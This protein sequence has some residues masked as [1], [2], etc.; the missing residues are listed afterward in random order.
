MQTPNIIKSIC[1]VG[2]GSAGWLT[3]AY[4][5]NNLPWANVTLVESANIPTIG[6]GEATIIN[7][8]DFMKDCGIM[9]GE[10]Q[11]A[12]DAVFK[13]GIL[14]PKWKNETTDIWHPFMFESARM[15]DGVEYTRTVL[16][17][18]AGLDADTW[19]KQAV[20]WYD[21]AVTKKQLPDINKSSV[22][23]HLDAI[24]LA[25]FLSQYCKSKY[26]DRLTHILADVN[27][28]VTDGENI[29]AVETSAGVV[30]NDFYIDCTGFKRILSSS[31]PGSQYINFDHM[32]FTNAAVATPVKY[33]SDDEI[34]PPYTI[35]EA[36][37]HGWI[38]KTS[39]EG[40]I[41]TGLVY[42]DTLLS[43]EAA[44]EYLTAHWGEDRLLTGKFNHIKFKP[45][46]NANNWRG[47]CFSIGLSSGFV[48]PLESTGLGLLV[49]G[50]RIGL[51]ILRKHFYIA[52]DRSFYNS[53]MSSLYVDSFD[54]VALHYMNN[55]RSGAFWD[56]VRTE[57]K[58][59]ATLQARL[60]LNKDEFFTKGS[61]Q[62]SLVFKEDS[63]R[64]WLMA[65]DNPVSQPDNL[66]AANKIKEFIDADNKTGGPT[67]NM[68]VK[69][70]RS[71]GNNRNPALK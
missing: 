50:A 63:W 31:I 22:G 9:P 56:K 24:K 45:E 34:I 67:N 26:K 55:S 66:M 57:F 59:S 21:L 38:W 18:Q 15:P 6:V 8:G 62:P 29:K 70:R 54:Y 69:F 61:E 43:A 25:N 14:F 20:S 44:Q 64:I 49:S 27:N 5:L 33:L 36:C 4:A 13:L 60:D 2:G 32:M 17:N 1:I 42:N 40:R 3:A 12:S 58:P 11:N 10:W 16:G 53:W 48:E 35:A 23:F 39:I 68:Y 46:Y 47:N 37:E 7:F 19:F 28:V 65:T 71:V 51:D 30:Q 41:G 52:D